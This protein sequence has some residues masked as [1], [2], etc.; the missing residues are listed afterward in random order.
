MFFSQSNFRAIK[1][2]C[3]S[4]VNMICCSL[5]VGFFHVHT[6]VDQDKVAWHLTARTCLMLDD[7]YSKRS[8]S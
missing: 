1:A 4:I 3:D 5:K 2:G 7:T 8:L 6:R